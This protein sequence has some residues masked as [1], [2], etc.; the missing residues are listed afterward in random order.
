MARSPQGRYRHLYPSLNQERNLSIANETLVGD[1]VLG[2]R[3]FGRAT[4]N[5]CL[6]AREC[7]WGKF[8][9]QDT[10]VLVLLTD[11]GQEHGFKLHNFTIGLSFTEHNLTPVT[12]D[13]LCRANTAVTALQILETP[14]PKNLRG[15]ETTQHLLTEMNVQ[16]EVSTGLANIKVGQMRRTKE[17]NVRSSWEY[18]GHRKSDE[19]GVF[20]IAK[21]V[22]EANHDNP[23]IEDVSHLYSGLILQHAG[24]PFYVGCTI[25]G[26]LVQSRQAASHSVRRWFKFGHREGEEP[27]VTKIMA[28]RSVE[29]LEDLEV[30]AKELE[31]KIER[32][33]RSGATSMSPQLTF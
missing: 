32:L 10:V 5:C 12:R 31:R 17:R 18:H 6:R 8:K 11:Q 29:D 27:K 28:H 1:T 3:D 14:S 9:D 22:W 20:T 4:V 16:P 7:T 33:I 24:E 30:V 15:G 26:Q 23:Q 13:N 25:R 21:W 2:Q 19:Y